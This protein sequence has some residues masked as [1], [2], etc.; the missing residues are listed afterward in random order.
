MTRT[1]D[2]RHDG[3]ESRFLAKL[4]MHNPV[5]ES[6]EE[7]VS[8]FQNG[9]RDAGYLLFVK[10]HRMIIKVILDRTKG[11]WFN[12][13]V[14]HAGAIGLYEAARRFDCTLGFTFLTYAVP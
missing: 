7:L 3:W 9:D 6:D 4:M 2:K 5:L 12:D 14:I 13:E 10:H 1:Q 8:R 11:R